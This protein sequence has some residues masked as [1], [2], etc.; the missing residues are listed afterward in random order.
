MSECLF[1]RIAAREIPSREVFSDERIYAFEDINPQA[2][3]HV[4]VIPR[5]HVSRVSE[6][7]EEDALL[8]GEVLRR[9]AAI[10]RE[11]GLTDFRVVANDGAGAGQSVFHLHFHVLGG[12][13]FSWPPG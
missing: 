2:P 11:R 12:R 10:A 3:V 8:A 6:L 4:L 9:A 1:C 5:K 7:A 13:P